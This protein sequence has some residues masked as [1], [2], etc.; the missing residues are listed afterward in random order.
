MF[1]FGK[2]EKRGIEPLSEEI[3]VE[4]KSTAASK[5]AQI[6]ITG[7]ISTDATGA[8]GGMVELAKKAL[9]QAVADSAVKAIVIRVDSPGGEVTASDTLFHAVRQA[10]DKK[11]VIIYMD[12]VAASGGYYLSCGATKIV[13]NENTW[14]GS[15]GVIVQ[16]FGYGVAFEK[17]GLEMRVFRSGDF[18]DTFYGQREMTP[19]EQEYVQSMV[20]QTYDRFVNVVS[21]ARNIPVDKLKGGIADGRVYSGVDALKLGL[22]DKTGYIETAYDLAKEAAGIKEAEIV[23]YERDPTLLELVGLKAQASAVPSKITL[24]VTGGL[25]TR[26]QPGRCYL[27]PAMFL[28]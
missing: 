16:G 8:G 25:L 7:I 13:A 20:M 12:S 2:V 1:H 23:R 6:D 15:I 17:L 19:A 5:I 10:R 9:S 22:I 14:T 11:P 27:L 26:L 18:K 28:Q 21:E 24:D 3:L 4:A